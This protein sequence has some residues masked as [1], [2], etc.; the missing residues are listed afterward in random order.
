MFNNADMAIINKPFNDLFKTII[1]TLCASCITWMLWKSYNKKWYEKEFE[2]K[3]INNTEFEKC[4]HNIPK[5]YRTH[6]MYERF[7]E[8][9][10]SNK[11]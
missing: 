5:K 10:K 11:S 2:I 1:G 6:E 8:K 3:L 9:C 4:F 7:F